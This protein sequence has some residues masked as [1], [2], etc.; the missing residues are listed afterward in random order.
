MLT[1]EIRD[2]YFA[3]TLCKMECSL[4]RISFKNAFEI[5]QQQQVD[6]SEHQR[7]NNIKCIAVS[8]TLNTKM[9]N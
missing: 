5:M 6:S 4:I 7:R 3:K 9:E 2:P 1:T 8:F